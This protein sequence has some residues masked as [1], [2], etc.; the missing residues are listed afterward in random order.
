MGGDAEA[1]NANAKPQPVPVRPQTPG[2]SGMVS[3][4][5]RN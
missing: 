2:P 5:F 1:E 4:T 3:L